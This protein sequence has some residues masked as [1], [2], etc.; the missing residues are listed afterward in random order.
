[1]QY[2]QQAF[3]WGATVMEK[4]ATILREQCWDHPVSR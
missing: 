3:V 2:K 4:L 1:M